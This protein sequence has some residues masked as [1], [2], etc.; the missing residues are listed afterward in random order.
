MKRGFTIVELVVVVVLIG[1]LVSIAVSTYD[2]QQKRS[3]DG[4]AK[5]LAA[6]VKAGAEKYYST[7]NEYP[8]ASIVY[9]GTPSGT[10]TPAS[11]ATASTVL[12]VPTTNLT[13]NNLKLL[14]CNTSTGVAATRC[15]SVSNSTTDKT[16]VY[17]ITKPDNATTVSTYVANSCTYTFPNTE[18]GALSFLVSYYSY[19]DSIW[20]VARSNRGDVTDTATN[21]CRFT[22]L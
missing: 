10:T 11:Y 5:N 20:K 21:G 6:A 22:A 19:Q 17:Y 3:Y 18:A 15:P 7:N 12:T 16:K 1:I 9:G 8:L 4:Q 14:P 2:A 13:T